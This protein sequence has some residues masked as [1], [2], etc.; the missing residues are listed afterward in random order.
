MKHA[1]NYSFHL[2]HMQ[3][4]VKQADELIT[5]SV[6]SYIYASIPKLSTLHQTLYESPIPEG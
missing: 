6:C 3:T 4:D 2:T 1:I 5:I